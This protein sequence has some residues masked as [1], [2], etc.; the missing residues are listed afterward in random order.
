MPCMV[1]GEWH[2]SSRCKTLGIP[3]DGFSKEYGGGGHGDDEEDSIGLK[4][5]WFQRDGQN[6]SQDGVPQTK[7]RG[8]T[9]L[10]HVSPSKLSNVAV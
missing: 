3:P 9:L 10:I 6:G 7:Q 2:W 1:C 5:L 8:Q 4:A